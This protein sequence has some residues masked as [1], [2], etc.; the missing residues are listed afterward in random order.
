MDFWNIFFEQVTST[1]WFRL[2]PLQKVQT[3]VPLATFFL[4]SRHLCHRV[5]L[6]EQR[7]AV[8]NKGPNKK[9]Y[10]RDPKVV[11]VRQK[12]INLDQYICLFGYQSS[13]R[14]PNPTFYR[15]CFQ[16]VRFSL[17][18]KSQKLTIKNIECNLSC[19]SSVCFSCFSMFFLV[20]CF[21]PVPGKRPKRVVVYPSTSPKPRIT[22][23]NGAAEGNDLVDW[24]QLAGSSE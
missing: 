16:V 12:L 5:V 7:W 22:C 14:C 6:K 18:F 19:V 11:H 15:L 4:V 1:T 21:W 24:W 20:F 17:C 2:H 23:R 10:Q 8:Q 3:Q 9:I 13:L